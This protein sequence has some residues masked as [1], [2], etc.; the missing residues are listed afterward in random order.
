MLSIEKISFFKA[1]PP[2]YLFANSSTEYVYYSGE[3]I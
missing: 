1:Y 3:T 2:L